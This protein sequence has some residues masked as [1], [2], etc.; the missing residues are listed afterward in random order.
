MDYIVKYS[1][2]KRTSDSSFLSHTLPPTDP[3]HNH[4][5]EK[6][7]N[8]LLLNIP[9]P[10]LKEEDLGVKEKKSS[11][12]RRIGGTRDSPLSYIH[13]GTPD[14]AVIFLDIQCHTRT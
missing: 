13:T 10:Q 4:V 12:F 6:R 2:R 1:E 9:I 8:W 14:V 5:R 3:V 7:E 11:E